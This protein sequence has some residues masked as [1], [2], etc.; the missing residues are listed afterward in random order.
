MAAIPVPINHIDHIRAG[1]S[2]R[3]DLSVDGISG[4]NGLERSSSQKGPTYPV[5]SP[6]KPRRLW[7][8]ART[9]VARGS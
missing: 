6:V 5:P 9:G 3:D 4:Q 2:L 7:M 8:T 1:I